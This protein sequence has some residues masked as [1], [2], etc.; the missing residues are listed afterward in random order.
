MY[1]QTTREKESDQ[2][3]APLVDLINVQI[4]Y[5]LYRWRHYSLERKIDN[6]EKLPQLS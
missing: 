4:I 1:K 6:S 2:L 3:L 5:T